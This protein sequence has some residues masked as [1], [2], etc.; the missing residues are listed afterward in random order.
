MLALRHRAS[1][2]SADEC[3]VFRPKDDVALNTKRSLVI[4]TKLLLRML[5]GYIV[6]IER[7][8]IS[9]R[10]GLHLAFSYR[11]SAAATATIVGPRS[12]GHDTPT[13]CRVHFGVTN[14]DTLR[15][16]VASIDC[17]PTVFMGVLRARSRMSGRSQVSCRRPTLN[18][19]CR[20]ASQLTKCASSIRRLS[21]LSR[22]VSRIQR[23]PF[24]MA[25]RSPLRVASEA[26]ALLR[27]GQP[28]LLRLAQPGFVS[29]REF[30]SFALVKV[31]A[32]NS[33]HAGHWIEHA[34]GDRV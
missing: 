8:S 26:C 20:P 10:E 9:T 24:F 23:C 15:V 30:D 12:S 7:T 17:A 28:Q 33:T 1:K 2:S 19:N 32:V 31:C 3:S 18:D 29:Y 6:S 4:L 25:F 5:P 16:N 11:C 14:N 13:D 22:S 27:R 34:I 21:R